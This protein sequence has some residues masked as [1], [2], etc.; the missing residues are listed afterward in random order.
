MDIKTLTYYRATF[1]WVLVG[2]LAI[3]FGGIV[4]IVNK[5]SKPDSESENKFPNILAIII[6]LLIWAIAYVTR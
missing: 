4:P 6:G 2:L 3:V 5:V 1:F